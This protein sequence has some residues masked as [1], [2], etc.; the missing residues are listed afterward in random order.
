MQLAGR[1]FQPI[2]QRAL[3]AALEAPFLTLALSRFYQVL[4]TPRTLHRRLPHSVQRRSRFIRNWYF[5]CRETG[6]FVNSSL[7][8]FLMSSLSAR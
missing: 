6:R 8:R 2:T 5:R 3:V 7:M 4:Q 1:S